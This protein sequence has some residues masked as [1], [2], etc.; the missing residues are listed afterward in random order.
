LGDAVG[1]LCGFTENGRDEEVQI[2]RV[3]LDSGVAYGFMNDIKD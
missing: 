2:K 1:F 3:C